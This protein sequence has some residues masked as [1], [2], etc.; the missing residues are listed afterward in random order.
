MA[1]GFFLGS[2]VLRCHGWRYLPLSALSLYMSG[3]RKF[4]AIVALNFVVAMMHC[5][6][7]L[8]RRRVLHDARRD[9]GKRVAEARTAECRA[10]VVVKSAEG[11]EELAVAKYSGALHDAEL[12][13]L[14]Q[15]YNRLR[16][17]LETA[18]CGD[19]APEHV[20][21]IQRSDL[22]ASSFLALK[23]V[24][25]PA[26]LTPNL[27]V[28]FRD[29]M[30]EDVGGV[31]RDWFDS[32]GR[33]LMSEAGD[34]APDHAP[35]SLFVI[36]PADG[37]LMIRRGNDLWEDYYALGSLF[38]LA[39]VH[40]AQ[41]PIRLSRAAWK[42]LLGCS[43][44]V[45]D[46]C[47]IDPVFFRNSVTAVLR[48][49][50][51]EEVS[52]FLGEPLRFVSLQ[53]ESC[54]GGVELV[55]GGEQLLVTEE[56]KLEYVELLCAFYLCGQVEREWH[57]LAR[58]FE[59]VL[60][61]EFLRSLDIDSHEFEMLLAGMPHV[62]VGD[63]RAHTLREGPNADTHHGERLSEWFWET[64]EEFDDEHRGKL[65]QFVTGSSH[66]PPGG[67][68]SLEPQ[69]C[70]YFSLGAPEQLPTAHTCVNQLNLAAY[71]S[72]DELSDRLRIISH[73]DCA[74]F[75]FR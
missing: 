71:P 60:P 21:T 61:R 56:N 52:S 3:T 34:G 59:D 73:S 41:V 58:G 39:V 10:P 32:V 17:L 74:G 68:R 14:Q 51:I 4:S 63:W 16:H 5:A 72:K 22:L 8:Q 6:H 20:V 30:G 29:E 49:G 11:R 42:L 46:V 54:A 67:F 38:A 15:N 13:L 31:L 75:G 2:S 37:T 26:L 12:Q 7:K 23:E 45:S 27:R 40:G 57:L 64:V 36:S 43:I 44:E 66:V 24:P 62:D 25:V 28:A 55:E 19:C 1:S 50:G 47:E 9:F 33:Q 69:F 53:S 18:T 70:L 65:L 35:R 48:P